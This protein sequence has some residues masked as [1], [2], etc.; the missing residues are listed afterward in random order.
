MKKGEMLSTAIHMATNA[1]HGQ[2]DRGGNPYILHVFAVMNFLE[3]PDEELQCI[4]LLHDIV[5]DTK[6][7]FQE[8][9]EAGFTDRVVEAVKLLTKMPGQTLEEYKEGVFSSVDAMKVKKADL[10]H[11]S[12]IRRLKGISDKDIERM[13]KYHR[14][15]LE[16]QS[17]L[18]DSG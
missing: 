4:A 5:E 1:H 16:I 15:F 10:T 9:R 14:F 6:T 2:F 12:D 18:Q 3:N 13:A 8:L 11:N 17:R 7:S